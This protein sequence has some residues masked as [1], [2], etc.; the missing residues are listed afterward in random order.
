MRH[1][2]GFSLVEALISL[3]LISLALGL[4]AQGMAKLS[5]VTR[6]SDSGSLKVELHSSLQR[7][8]SELASALTV[9]IANPQ[10]LDIS[11]VD[12]SLNRTY[13]ESRDRLPWPWPAT[14]PA[15]PRDP[16]QPAYLIHV[17]YRLQN[18]N[19][20]ALSGTET[21]MVAAD[22]ADWKVARNGRLLEIDF[23]ARDAANGRRLSA[24][25]FLP[26]VGP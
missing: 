15:G 2:R 17:A 3:A 20:V 6:A 13:N 1:G 11:R 10:S 25:A 19:L 26:L 16:N 22:L 18:S 24:V 23:V 4:V 12:P 8:C 7:L 5:K 14:L 21:E 9:T